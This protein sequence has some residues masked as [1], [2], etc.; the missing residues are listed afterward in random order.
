M[1]TVQKTISATEA[2]VHFGEVLRGVSEDNA[3]YVV[4][5]NGEAQAVV[6]SPEEFERLQRG[7]QTADWVELARK[8]REAFRPLMESGNVP[9]IEDLIR[10]E[11]EKRDAHILAVVS[12][13]ELDCEDYR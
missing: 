1:F 6:I 2:R 5:R 7:V 4:E 9:N 8:S 13:R 11:R 3:I 12:G 10:E